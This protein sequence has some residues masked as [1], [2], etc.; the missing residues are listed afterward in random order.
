MRLNINGVV[1]IYSTAKKGMKEDQKCTKKT[2]FLKKLTCSILTCNQNSNKKVNYFQ[3]QLKNLEKTKIRGR[4]YKTMKSKERKKEIKREK[5]KKKEKE[6][7]KLR[8]SEI[9]LMELGVNRTTSAP[10]SV[11]H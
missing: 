4:N 2:T 7:K 6:R 3:K 5:R 10:K 11:L 9:H 1:V 8:Y